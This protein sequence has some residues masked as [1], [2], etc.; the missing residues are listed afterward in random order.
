MI[1]LFIHHQNVTDL[2]ID[3]GFALEHFQP[4]R[5]LPGNPAF[6]IIVRLLHQKECLYPLTIYNCLVT[7]LQSYNYPDCHCNQQCSHY[8][9]NLTIIDFAILQS[10]NCKLIIAYDHDAMYVLTTILH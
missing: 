5:R 4:M 6:P 7:I 8:N 3:N 2:E 9:F 10:Y 1:T